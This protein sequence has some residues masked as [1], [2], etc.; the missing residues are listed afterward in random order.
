MTDESEPEVVEH[1]LQVQEELGRLGKLAKI[2]SAE[3]EEFVAILREF[4]TWV[5][6]EV[7]LDIQS[8]GYAF[9]GDKEAYLDAECNLVIVGERG[10]TVKKP[11]EQLDPALFL[12][13]ARAATPR[14]LKLISSRTTPV[15][16]PPPLKPSLRVILLAGKKASDSKIGPHRFFVMNHGGEVQ[17][18]VVSVRPMY[19]IGTYGKAD[20]YGPM[21]IKSGEQIELNLHQPKE[22][23]GLTSLAVEVACKGADG[24]VYRGRS[25]IVV[26]SHQWLEIELVAG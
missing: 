15:K 2:E 22:S 18:L 10:G 3:R 6:T 7:K 24:R 16:E 1:L 21:K 4:Q 23:E 17:E 5:K 14:L 26:E 12:I 20:A 8:L 13:I 19:S 11:I 25:A 9:V